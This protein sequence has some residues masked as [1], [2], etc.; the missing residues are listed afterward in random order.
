MVRCVVKFHAWHTVV[1]LWTNPLEPWGPAKLSSS[2]LVSCTE[3]NACP[4]GTNTTE[5]SYVS[6]RPTS[7]LGTRLHYVMTKIAQFE[8]ADDS[9]DRLFTVL[10]IYT[11]LRLVICNFAQF[12]LLVRVEHCIYTCSNI[13]SLCEIKLWTINRHDSDVN[14]RFVILL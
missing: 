2:R 9:T 10:K 4:K 11:L 7:S 6:E 8:L 12:S 14:V 13:Q 3:L 5:C 1:S